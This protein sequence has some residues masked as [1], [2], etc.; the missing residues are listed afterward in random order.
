MKHFRNRKSVTGHF[1]NC[2]HPSYI[3][4]KQEVFDVL[5]RFAF[6]Y[7]VT[8]MVRGEDEGAVYVADWYNG[9]YQ[10]PLGDPYLV[11]IEYNPNKP[12]AKIY[13]YLRQTFFLKIVEIVSCDLAFDIIGASRSDVLVKTACDIMTYGKQSNN[14][15]Y[16]APKQD[17]SGRVKVYQKDKERENNGVTIDKTLRIELTVKKDIL[18]APC[19]VGSNAHYTDKAEV[20]LL[21]CCEHLNAVHIKTAAEATEDWKVYALAHLSPE[22]LSQCLGLMS[23]AT[24]GKYRDLATEVSY[25]TLNIDALTLWITLWHA[26]ERWCV[27]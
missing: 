23:K 6:R 25:E 11:L 12:G 1:F 19:I 17:Q 27:R 5:T 13:D 15:L 22:D 8:L 21:R 16:I 4:V 2:R 9:D 3:E 20:A 7:S 14:T 18:S 26:L 10:N 24:R